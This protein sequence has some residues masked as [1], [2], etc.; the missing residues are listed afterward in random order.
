M[1][2]VRSFVAV[3][4]PEDVKAA[5]AAAQRELELTGVRV[6]WASAET[7][8]VTVKFLGDVER[9]QLVEVARAVE[10]VAAQCEPWEAELTGLGWFP[11]RGRPRVVW[12][13]VEAGRVRLIELA[14]AVE[15]AL[16]PLGFPL[17][18]RR[19]HPHVTLGRV[20]S[21]GDL[22]VLTAA[23]KEG[24]GRR[25]GAFEVDSVITFES[26]LRPKGPIHTVVATARLGCRRPPEP[27]AGG[28]V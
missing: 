4:L 19:F 17:E 14:E 27:D 16:E 18:S 2:R 21:S 10:G 12:A 22:S 5:L 6:R 20:R 7:L 13:G 3:E 11:P 28:G 24:G 9:T 23:L 1:E 15:G 25:F 26:E 8:H